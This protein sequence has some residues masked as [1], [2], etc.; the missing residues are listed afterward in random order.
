MTKH[1]FLVLAALAV[2]AFSH[3]QSLPGGERAKSPTAQEAAAA[4]AVQQPDEGSPFFA[5]RETAKFAL[6]QEGQA[7]KANET[8]ATYPMAKNTT[9][10][11]S[12]MFTQFFT[13]MFSSIKWGSFHSDKTTEKLTI[14]PT[15]FSLQDR[16]E[17]DVIYTVRNN[18][19]KIIRFD[20][21]TTQR[22]D[23]MTRDAS[24]NVIDRWSEDRAFTPQEGIVILNPKERIEYSEKI[25]TRD[26]KPDQTYNVGAEISGYPDYTATK[27]VTPSP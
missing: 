5:D 23:I 1:A 17:L 4:F 21:G 19:G 8:V 2:P 15:K 26:M 7:E 12:S 24:G 3:G 25:P 11:A 20:Y 10:S 18:T 22:I 9:A 14:E 16:R 13:G 27:T 6:S